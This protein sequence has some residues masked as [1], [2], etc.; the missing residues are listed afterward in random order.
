ML[1]MERL[2]K[3]GFLLLSTGEGEG[4]RLRQVAV[5]QEFLL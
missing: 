1:K 4:H 2:P 5:R 3:S